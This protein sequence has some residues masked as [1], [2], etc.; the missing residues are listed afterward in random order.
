MRGLEIATLEQAN[1]FTEVWGR[2]RW[3]RR[4]FR[5]CALKVDKS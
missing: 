5:W 3:G 4:F 1:R 2:L